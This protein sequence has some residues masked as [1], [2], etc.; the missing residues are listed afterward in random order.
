MEIATVL[1]VW[2]S[3]RFEDETEYE[4][5]IQRKVFVRVLK[6]DTQGSFILLHLTKK[7]GT[8]IY[9]KGG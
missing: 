8:V 1:R 5:E 6:K 7:V 9:T 3:F 2:G 4:Y